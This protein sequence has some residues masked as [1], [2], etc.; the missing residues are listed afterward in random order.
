MGVVS[1]SG[2]T[3]LWPPESVPSA[4]SVGV[5]GCGRAVGRGGSADC[6]GSPNA[7]GIVPVGLD[8]VADGAPEFAPPLWLAGES[9]PPD[10]AGLL[11]S[12][13]AGEVS[14]SSCSGTP[15]AD[16]PGGNATRGAPAFLPG[17][18]ARP[19]PGSRLAFLAV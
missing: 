17:P 19:W 1:A 10:R 2:L 11:P 6:K 15:A 12:V 5:T 13:G 3:V 8:G 7:G 14:E 18:A 4:P 9:E 16:G